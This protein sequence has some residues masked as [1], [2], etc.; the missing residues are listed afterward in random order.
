VPEVRH[1]RQHDGVQLTKQ[2]QAAMPVVFRDGGLRYYFFSN[3]GTPREPP[4]THVN[5]RD[6]DAKQA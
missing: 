5:G 1:V 3:D 2:A 4:H 6:C